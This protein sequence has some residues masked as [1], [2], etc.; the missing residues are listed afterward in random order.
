MLAENIMFMG[1]TKYDQKLEILAGSREP[2]NC[3]STKQSTK[4]QANK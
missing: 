1:I 3:A 2:T 4:Q